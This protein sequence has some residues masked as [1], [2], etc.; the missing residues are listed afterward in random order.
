MS[1]FPGFLYQRLHEITK[2]YITLL[3]FVM[4]FIALCGY[5]SQ[6]VSTFLQLQTKSNTLLRKKSHE[7]NVRNTP[8]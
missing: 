7:K 3:Q 1:Q 6:F 4:H 8:E 2:I 5:V